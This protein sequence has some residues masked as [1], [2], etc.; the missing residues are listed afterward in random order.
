MILT[1]KKTGTLRYF[2]GTPKSFLAWTH[3]FFGDSSFVGMERK[4]KPP[5]TCII[6]YTPLLPS[7]K[8]TQLWKITVFNGKIH[9]KWPF[10]IAML[11]YQRV[12]SGYPVIKHGTGIASFYRFFFGPKKNLQ[13]TWDCPLPRGIFWDGKKWKKYC[14]WKDQPKKNRWSV[15]T[16]EISQLSIY[17]PSSGAA[18]LA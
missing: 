3:Y 16:A 4:L 2:I 6:A 11:N 17:P 10:S 18:K 7:G 8:L 12:P 5:L 1:G 14:L 13:F 15:V 9:Y